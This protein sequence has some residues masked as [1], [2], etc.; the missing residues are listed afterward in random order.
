MR[1]LFSKFQSPKPSRNNFKQ[2]LT[3]FQNSLTNGNNSH[4]GNYKTDKVEIKSE[5]MD[6][7][8][9]TPTKKVSYD[10]LNAYGPQDATSNPEAQ[11]Y[12]SSSSASKKP[13]SIKPEIVVSPT[14][15][16]SSSDPK[17]EPQFQLT[18]TK[19]PNLASTEVKKEHNTSKKDSISS[20]IKPSVSITPISSA[21][22]S[23][24]SASNAKKAGIEIIPLGG[25]S[26][27]VILVVI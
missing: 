12:N 3:N 22:S 19:V 16:L 26:G 9:V 27:Y 17:V 5:P 2:E 24:I 18:K 20:D 13:S 11:I 15:T 10:S 6:F 1:S 14:S 21:Q 4:N 23:T 25:T 8:T 7:E